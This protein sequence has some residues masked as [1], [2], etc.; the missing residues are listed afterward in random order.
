[1]GMRIHG[2]SDTAS[3]QNLGA[4]NW[5]RRQQNLNSLM[6][7]IQSGDLGGAQQALQGLTGGTGNVAPGSPLA[8]IAKAVQ[9]ENLSAAQGAA[10]AF[11]ALRSGGDGTHKPPSSGSTTGTN[12]GGSLSANGGPGSLLDEFA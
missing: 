2:A 3:A 6:S 10:R 4:A 12:N 11:K 1:M 5:Q 8:A 7:S 9:S